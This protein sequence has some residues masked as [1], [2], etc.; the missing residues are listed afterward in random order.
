MKRKSLLAVF[1]LAVCLGG[2]ATT[3]TGPGAESSYPP[4]MMSSS[5]ESPAPDYS[6]VPETSRMRPNIERIAG[7]AAL[8]HLRNLMSRN[9]EAFAR[10]RQNL[11]ARGYKPTDTV[12][13]ERTL[14]PLKGPG[15][16]SSPYQLVQDYSES[17]A[18]GEILFWSWS[19]G[20]NNTWEGAIHMVIYGNGAESTW[21][22]Q[23]DASTS[24]HPWVW[25]EKSWERPPREP[26][27]I[28]YSFP[29]PASRGGDVIHLAR[30]GPKWTNPHFV[31]A[32]SFY[33]W[34][35]CWRAGVVSGCS[36]AA[37]GCIATNGGWAGCW[38]AWCTGT[39]VGAGAGCY[40]MN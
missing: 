26:I 11:A 4:P 9:P 34:A 7:E 36:T 23:I 16:S 39:L 37:V 13:V 40:F 5:Q 8:T 6:N 31:P 35:R 14:R 33:N 2:C 28:R 27:E 32:G 19:D 1:V 3:T 17:N 29:P 15:S 38:G 24:E 21:D 18:D 22:G 20:N 12:Y 10:S 30:S 25:Y